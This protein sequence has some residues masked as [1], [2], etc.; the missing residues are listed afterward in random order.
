[1]GGDKGEDAALEDTVQRQRWAD[2]RASGFSGRGMSVLRCEGPGE[3]R[4]ESGAVRGRSHAE[5]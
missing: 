4:G 1:M 3:R 5:A 2:G